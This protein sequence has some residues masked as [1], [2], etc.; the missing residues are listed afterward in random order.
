MAFG[1]LCRSLTRIL[2]QTNEEVICCL[3]KK[4]WGLMPSTET[5]TTR[6]YA[7]KPVGIN[8]RAAKQPKLGPQASIML[9]DSRGF[10]FAFNFWKRSEHHQLSPGQAHHARGSANSLG[11]PPHTP[12]AVTSMTLTLTPKATGASS[13]PGT[14]ATTETCNTSQAATPVRFATSRAQMI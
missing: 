14:R 12:S 2:M 1:S 6:V 3:T 11:T 9:E 10:D 13:S 7:A 4:C 5:R 8:G